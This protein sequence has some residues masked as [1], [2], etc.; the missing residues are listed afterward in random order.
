MF[1]GFA[2]GTGAGAVITVSGT[3]GVTV[4]TMVAVVT[5]TAALVDAVA[6]GAGGF[7]GGAAEALG[8]CNLV[9][10]FEVEADA[11]DAAAAA[12]WFCS[13]ADTLCR[14]CCAVFPDR[15]QATSS[16]LRSGRGELTRESASLVLLRWVKRF[17]RSSYSGKPPGNDKLFLERSIS[18]LSGCVQWRDHPLSLS[19][20]RHGCG[21]M[22]LLFRYAGFLYSNLPT[23]ATRNDTLNPLQAV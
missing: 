4:V 17:T 23:L 2:E 7:A 6:G 8:A 19:I 16:S 18:L 22:V 12:C 20:Y 5:F 13:C 21:H 1:A 10:R 3:T 14:A 15:M 9:G 11:D